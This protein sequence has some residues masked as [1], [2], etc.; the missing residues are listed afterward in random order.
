MREDV[1]NVIKG[2]NFTYR[3]AL[4]NSNVKYI[5]AY[6]SFEDKHKLKVSMLN[7]NII[8][9]L[10][11]LLI[12]P[13]INQLVDKSG[14]E[15]FLTAKN[16]IIATGERPKYPDIPGAKEYGITSDDLFSLP[17][18][19]GKTLVVGASYVALEC[20]GFLREIG[21][22]VTVM[23][24]SILLRGFDQ[25]MAEKIGEY[26]SEDVGIKFLRPCTPISVEQLKAGNPGKLLV[27]GK[28]GDGKIVQDEYNTVIF[29]I[30][31]I[32]CTNKIGLEKVGVK[33]DENGKIPTVNDQTNVS[34]I[35]AVGDIVKGRPELTPVAIKAGLFLAQRLSGKMDA[36]Y[37]SSHVPTTIFTPLE[38]SSAGIS[39][40]VA[41][42]TYGPDNIE[43]YHQHFT[44]TEWTVPG[45]PKNKCY[46]K[47][48]CLIPEK[49]G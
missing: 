25:E 10:Q 41:I 38:Y 20:A 13:I 46:V 11:S 24:R 39:E 49:V 42:K 34:N 35:Y 15:S 1:Q 19:P 5:N 12:C 17:Y 33:V 3:V 48:I 2:S 4:R 44:P 43:V 31:R 45:R 8:T 22:D 30:G 7:D 14:S 28:M 32:P 23:V 9:Y 40:E 36:Q 21:L 47:L 16:F 18:C 37:D 27:K 29:A 26:M 6:G